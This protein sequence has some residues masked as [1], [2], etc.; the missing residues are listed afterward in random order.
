MKKNPFK[1]CKTINEVIAVIRTK[2]E[3]LRGKKFRVFMVGTPWIDGDQ[4]VFRIETE[5]TRVRQKGNSYDH[6]L[7][8]FEVI[9]GERYYYYPSNSKLGRYRGEPFEDILLGGGGGGSGGKPNTNWHT[10]RIKLKHIPHIKKLHEQNLKREEG[11]KK[12]RDREYPYTQGDRDI[13]RAMTELNTRVADWR[14]T[15]HFNYVTKYPQFDLKTGKPQKAE[16]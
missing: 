14:D 2:C 10:A 13:Q 16:R 8:W 11:A 1:D 6:T 5:Y 3:E 12:A 7:G 15:N 4:L 9:H